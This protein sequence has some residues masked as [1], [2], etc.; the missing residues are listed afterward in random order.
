MESIREQYG[1]ISRE[2]RYD[3]SVTPF[4][5]RKTVLIISVS[6]VLV[7]LILQEF[8]RGKRPMDLGPIPKLHNINL[9]LGS[10]A[11]FL[12][13]AYE[14]YK[15]YQVANDARFIFCLPIGFEVKGALYFW[16]Y[17]YYLS[18]YYE[19]FDTVILVLRGKG[20]NF[21]HV[22][23]HAF[24]IMMAYLWLECAQSLQT[25]ALLTNTFIHVIMYMYYFLV[26]CGYHPSWKK[27]ITQAQIVQFIFSFMCLVPFGLHYRDGGCSG[28]AALLFNAAFNAALIVLF[29]NFFKK[30]YTKK[31]TKEA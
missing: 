13:A 5:E 14:A 16:S 8:R 10:L 6:Y 2:F 7:M 22:F 3:P 21:L 9:C 11:M 30:S 15:E 19:L 29:G 28:S 23:H 17:I 31:D 26:S 20:L 12:G 27:L 4:C 24:V 1:R 18:K 25:I